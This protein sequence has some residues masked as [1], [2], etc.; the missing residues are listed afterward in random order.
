MPTITEHSPRKV[1]EFYRALGFVIAQRYTDDQQRRAE[2]EMLHQGST[3][4]VQLV[5][6]ESDKVLET[7]QREL[8]PIRFMLG[9]YAAEANRAAHSIEVAQL[10]LLERR[11]WS[12][13]L[14]DRLELLFE[15]IP[16]S[17]PFSEPN[18]VL[19]QLLHS[20]VEEMAEIC[21][22]AICQ[23]LD[24]DDLRFLTVVSP[25]QAYPLIKRRVTVDEAV[26]LELFT[27]LR[28][29]LLNG[30]RWGCLERLLRWQRNQL[31]ELTRILLSEWQ[32]EV[33]APRE[34]KNS[35]GS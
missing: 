25:A 11:N 35:I 7:L 27:T 14:S 31:G 9:E 2:Q 8:M 10:Q 1:A 5:V 32:A 23:K 33:V 3:L 26:Q 22:I 13:E 4:A 17:P 28:K 20:T 6:S 18:E 16:E 29:Y 24:E 34:T 21:C 19:D 30:D 15:K 12:P